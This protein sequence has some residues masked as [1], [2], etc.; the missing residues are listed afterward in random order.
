[1]NPA[2]LAQVGN[3]A[4][5]ALQ[6]GNLDRA[7]RLYLQLEEHEPANTRWIASL[8]LVYRKLTRRDDEVE[9]LARL[10]RVHTE[11]GQVLPAIAALK[12][13]LAVVPEHPG[14]K[15]AL[16]ALSARAAGSKAPSRP[17][18]APIPAARTGSAAHAPLDRLSL[19]Q[20][21]PGTPV[22]GKPN[23]HRVPLG[24]EDHGIE[25]DLG[26]PEPLVQP[27]KH[28]PEDFSLE[29]ALLDDV[30]A[31][32]RL[33]E[34]AQ[35]VLPT[36]GLFSA[37]DAA[38]FDRLVVNA[39]MVLKA[40]GEEVF[41]QNAPAD[42]LYV[43]ADGLVGVI[44][45]GPPRRG[46]AKLGPGEIFGETAIVTDRTRTAS[47]VA[48][49]PTELIAIDRAQVQVLIQEHPEALVAL[50]GFVRDRLI[51]RLLA[52]HPLF[53]VLSPADCERIR[54]RFRFFEAD[55][56]AHLIEVGAAPS[57]LFVILAGRAS[58]V[59]GGQ[60]VA[61]LETG[62]IAGER[63][64]LTGAA[65]EAAVIADSKCWVVAFAAED[66]RKIVGARP[67]AKAYVDTLIARRA[68][69]QNVPR[70]KVR[71]G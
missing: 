47:V 21:I 10:A 71:W 12:R 28:A 32:V 8:A 60:T 19:R 34:R 39:K 2:Q 37:L 31:E 53:S 65:P 43:V 33:A 51:G 4:D 67:E 36:V 38:S 57:A 61:T 48:I 66:F 15:R 41:H 69:A 25:L 24:G 49:R 55:P 26:P 1:M 5:L 63:S 50:L 11:A 7:L 30:A 18:V 54:G 45:E 70:N 52:T 64:I 40:A 3:D 29:E 14:A 9:T 16:A 62:D 6:Q 68:R 56:G 13:V 22:A 17:A 42:A 58:V 59:Q 44:D 35:A 46:I 27:R 23:L 20:I